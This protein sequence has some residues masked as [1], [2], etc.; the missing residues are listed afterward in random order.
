MSRAAKPSRATNQGPSKPTGGE[1]V[2]GALELGAVVEE[3][4]GAYR[5]TMLVFLD[6]ASGFGFSP[7]LVREVGE[8]T[9][10]EA[11]RG[12]LAEVARLGV[13]A[14]PRVRVAD[15]GLARA[16][17]TAVGG[18]VEVEVAATPEV[19]VFGALLQEWAT[20]GAPMSYFHGQAFPSEL[21]REFF[22]AALAFRKEQPW[23]L[24]LAEEG[25]LFDVPELGVEGAAIA[26]ITDEGFGGLQIFPSDEA[27]Q[28]L[29]NAER[30]AQAREATR[31]SRAVMF[32]PRRQLPDSLREELKR[33]PF[34]PATGP[35]PAIAALDDRGLQRP[36]LRSDYAIVI[37]ALRA[38]TQFVADH[39]EAL[40]EGESVE[41]TYTVSCDEA[42][43]TAS[44]RLG[45]PQSSEDEDSDASRPA[46]EGS[47]P[48]PSANSV[49]RLKLTLSGARPAIWRLVEV[50]S[51]M[52][53]AAL[54]RVLQIVMDWDDEHLH[55]FRHDGREIGPSNTDEFD[56]KRTELWAVLGPGARRLRYNYDFGDDWVVDIE[57]VEVHEAEAPIAPRCLDGRRAGPPEDCGGLT[58]LHALVRRGATEDFD[59]ARF[60]IEAVNHRL[61]RVARASDRAA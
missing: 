40:D 42:N 55:V 12:L 8:A 57:A 5:P 34:A 29:A 23:E 52:T 30:E 38:V 49:H 16:L 37:A 14:P 44:L 53:L 28:A 27:L 9:V 13:A 60:S 17:R 18:A 36:L 26:V 11:W 43:V 56:E 32:Y 39:R 20:R 22:A 51:T 45:F 31:N 21:V 6:A 50:P 7:H 10:A 19:A 4:G 33:L 47:G 48:R 54:H 24:L 25:I 46:L 15:E 3:A 61:A 2:F 58:G 1:L 59:P 41:A 35:I